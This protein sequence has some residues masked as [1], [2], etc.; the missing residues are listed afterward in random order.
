[1]VGGFPALMIRKL[2]RRLNNLQCW[3]AETVRVILRTE[4][5]AA[6]AVVGTL[7]EA[8]LAVSQPELGVGGYQTTP[9][10]QAFGSATAAKPITRRTADRALSQLIE[11]IDQVNRGE[12]FLAKVT[13]VVVLG[14]YLRADVDRLSDVDVAVELQ[15]KEPDWDRLRELNRAR[16]E[17]LHMAGRRFSSWIAIEYWWH[18]E[19]FSFLKGR[20]R[21][22]S[23]IDYKDE[24]EFVDR[25]PHRVLFSSVAGV[26]TKSPNHNSKGPRRRSLR[27]S[28]CPF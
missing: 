28:D 19:A 1:L 9:L 26:D 13:K 14:S 18:L 20:S 15:P 4:G 22:I 17:H 7:L 10:A 23:L 5:G 24:R 6:E 11:R 25:V 12:S 2:V 21:A 3:N 27:P 8:G 16:V